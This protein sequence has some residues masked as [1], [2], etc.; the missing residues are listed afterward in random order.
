MW[1]H[2]L[3]C[4]LTL[5]YLSVINWWIFTSLTSHYMTLRPIESGKALSDL[6]SSDLKLP[7]L[8]H[9]WWYHS[10]ILKLLFTKV[11]NFLFLTYLTFGDFLGSDFLEFFII[12]QYLKPVF[13]LEVLLT[14]VDNTLPSFSFSSILFLLLSS[15]SLSIWRAWIFSKMS[16]LSSVVLSWS[17]ILW[18]HSS[19]SSILKRVDN[20]TL[21]LFKA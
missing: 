17:C 7:S 10:C 21:S 15:W 18:S 12:K 4:I 16:D 20:F 6:C 5:K 1:I 2:C 3:F 9:Y 8:I 11:S 13:I 19:W 14:S